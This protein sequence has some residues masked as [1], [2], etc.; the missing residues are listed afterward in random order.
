M[1]FCDLFLLVERLGYWPGLMVRRLRICGFGT[2]GRESPETRA[3]SF[4]ELG[5]DTQRRPPVFS[6]HPRWPSSVV[7]CPGLTTSIA[8]VWALEWLQMPHMNTEG[9]PWLPFLLTTLKMYSMTSFL[10]KRASND[11]AYFNFYFPDLQWALTNGVYVQSR[12]SPTPNKKPPS[13]LSEPVCATQH[14]YFRPR[15]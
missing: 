7:D 12:P 4:F 1:V 2:H 6:Q 8:P 3:Q 5:G 10:L 9:S 15:V 14:L 11:T 13:H